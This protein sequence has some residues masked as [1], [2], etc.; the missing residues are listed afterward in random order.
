MNKIKV[1]IFPLSRKL[2]HSSYAY[3]LATSQLLRSSKSINQKTP[4]AERSEFQKSL[5]KRF[6]KLKLAVIEEWKEWQGG[7]PTSFKGKSYAYFL[8]VKSMLDPHELLMVELS[9]GYRANRPKTMM[10]FVHPSSMSEAEARAEVTKMLEQL[11]AANWKYSVGYTLLTPLTALAAVLP[12]PNVFLLG[13]LL[14]IYALYLTRITAKDLLACLH[15][16]SAVDAAGGAA[17]H[18]KFTPACELNLKSLDWMDTADF[19][20]GHGDTISANTENIEDIIADINMLVDNL[21][22]DLTTHRL[23]SDAPVHILDEAR[24]QAILSFVRY[25]DKAHGS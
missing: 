24:R 25:H 1:C 16:G 15:S 6:K 21:E 14:R 18:I 8:K 13:N 7:E 10:N 3:V 17:H 5:N 20:K 19:G 4:R 2:N 9:D 23:H 12:G 11:L 22:C